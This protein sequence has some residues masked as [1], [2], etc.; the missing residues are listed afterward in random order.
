[1]INVSGVG[2]VLIKAT[3]TL[4]NITHASPADIEVLL[5]SPGAQDTF[6]MANAGGQNPLNKV[7][8]KFDDAA[9]NSLPPTAYPQTSITN[10]TYKP[11][12]WLP[13]PNFP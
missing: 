7:T 5:V 11:T 10:G 2:G 1:V 13:V 8:L 12:A 4:T 6:I 9:T 3:T